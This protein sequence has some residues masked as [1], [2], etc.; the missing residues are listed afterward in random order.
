MSH[1]V[2]VKRGISQEDYNEI[3]GFGALCRS[4][5]VS[6]AFDCDPNIYNGCTVTVEIITDVLS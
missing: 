1:L 4:I 5:V 3:G 6:S 2:K